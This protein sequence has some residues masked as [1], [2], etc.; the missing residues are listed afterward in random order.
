M[1]KET[2]KSLALLLFRGL[3]SSMTAKMP[4]KLRAQ[5]QR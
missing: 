2:M 5:A 3:N 1:K 4:K